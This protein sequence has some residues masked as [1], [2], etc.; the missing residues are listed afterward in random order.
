MITLFTLMLFQ[1]CKFTSLQYFF[2]FSLTTQIQIILKYLDFLLLSSPGKP[3]VYTALRKARNDQ[4]K[5]VLTCLITGF[6][7]RDIEMDIRFNKTVLKDQ[8]SSG[9]RP[10]GDGS[11]QMKSSVKI[12][13][14]LEGIYD[15]FV[16]HSS[17]TEP[18]ERVVKCTDCEESKWP[19]EAVALVS[20]LLVA[21]LLVA[22][23][24]L[25][26]C[27]KR[28]SDENNT[29]TAETHDHLQ[30]QENGHRNGMLL[31]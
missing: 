7:P 1:I 28:R 12:N 30:P 16:N 10:N 18:V 27:Y 8:R 3:E 23:L 6:Y 20:A 26:L 13:R 29:V 22:V 4:N 19:K 15:C 24:V 9:V 11:F 2:F 5:Q 25:V 14:S 17:L 21:A 31:Q